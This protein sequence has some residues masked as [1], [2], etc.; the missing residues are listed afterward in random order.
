MHRGRGQWHHP[1]PEVDGIQKPEEALPLQGWGL[2]APSS[3]GKDSRGPKA[4]THSFGN[5]TGGVST[6]HKWGGG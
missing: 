2:T 5:D 4:G 6:L 3:L 1:V